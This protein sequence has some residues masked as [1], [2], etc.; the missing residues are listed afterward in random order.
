MKAVVKYA[1]QDGCTEIRD[2]PVPAI[3]PGE[4]LVEVAYVGI[5][6]SDPH[7]HHQ[8]VTYPLEVPLILGHEFAGRIVDVGPSAGDWAVG[9]RVTAET[10]AE[11]CGRCSLCHA[12]HYHLCRDRKGYGFRVNGAFARYVRVPVRILHRVPESVDLRQ[13]ALTE[14]FCVAYQA[15]INNSVLK[16][17]DTVCIIGPGPIG[18]L[19]TA[20]ASLAGAAEI[21]VAGTTGDGERLEMARQYGATTTTDVAD[22]LRAAQ[23]LTDGYGADLVVDTA[24][25]SATLKLSLDVVRP[26]GQITKVGWGP[27]PVGFS[28]DQLIGKSVRLQGSFSHT[29][30][31]WEK[32]LTLMGK[33]KMDL[34]KLITHELPLEE[35][36]R[37]F[38]IIEQ[39]RGL[40]VVLVPA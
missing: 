6:G 17:G 19:C 40:K 3:G 34:S 15:V 10:H 12:N 38:E 27:E 28:L 18:I 21:I 33:G 16:P 26:A 8:D 11:Y 9:D 7:I 4:A 2:V 22:A 35:W 37:G 14:P 5:C 39:R 24:G 20:M 31:V 36:A 25:P 30:D 23:E 29:W 32:C 13:A 1:N